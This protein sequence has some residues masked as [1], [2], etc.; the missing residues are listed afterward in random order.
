MV[1]LELPGILCRDLITWFSMTQTLKIQHQE[2]KK[3]IPIF[4]VLF[5]L[6]WKL[7][8]L[9]VFHFSS[10]RW[11]TWHDPRYSELHLDILLVTVVFE[12]MSVIR[13]NTLILSEKSSKNYHRVLLVVVVV[14]LKSHMRECSAKWCAGRMECVPSPCVSLL[15]CCGQKGWC[16]ISWN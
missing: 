9:S 6:G 11:L 16:N 5:W 13:N 3:V 2:H 8:F 1:C 10:S 12:F 7:F 15:G 14:F 4:K